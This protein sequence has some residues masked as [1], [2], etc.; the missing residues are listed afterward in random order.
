MS[1]CVR[2][3]GSIKLCPSLPV[4]YPKPRRAT[5]SW[6]R[7]RCCRPI[8]EQTLDRWS[9]NT[10]CDGQLQPLGFGVALTEHA[11]VVQAVVMVGR[12][13]IGEEQEEG[14]GIG[15]E[16]ATSSSTARTSRRPSAF[17]LAAYF[18]HRKNNIRV[19]G[20]LY[21]PAERQYRHKCEAIRAERPSAKRSI[22]L[23]QA[24]LVYSIR[25]REVDMELVC[26]RHSH[27][28]IDD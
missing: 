16:S 17:Q 24:V 20:W 14:I 27:R 8:E 15:L 23:Q 26:S 7:S 13:D 25:I 19:I 1:A 6:R 11:R 18:W 21:P 28:Q 4:C 2:K 3:P 10:S 9:L 5:P 12:A 22:G